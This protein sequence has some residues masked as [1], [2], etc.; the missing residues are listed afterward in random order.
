MK[1]YLFGILAITA[2]G[3]S[4]FTTKKTLDPVS[5]TFYFV[6]GSSF[7][8]V[9]KD[10]TLGTDAQK[11]LNIDLQENTSSAVMRN[12]SLWSDDPTDGGTASVYLD[13]TPDGSSYM[14]KFTIPSFDEG[15]NDNNSTDG[16]SLEE[17]L[18]AIQASYHS[19]L[20]S[21][22]ALPATLD[23]NLAQGPTV[24]DKRGK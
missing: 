4:A 11:S 15:G 14:W 5:T 19:S 12:L 2:I 10:I 22:G 3:L 24:T 20:T 21:G 23:V 6:S 16:I 13:G 8:R 7:Q 17:A 18:I 9:E 1:K